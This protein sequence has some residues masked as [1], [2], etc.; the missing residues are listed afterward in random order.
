MLP[1]LLT[2]LLLYCQKKIRRRTGR[3]RKF[4]NEGS[5]IKL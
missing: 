1:L 3:I 4:D 2:E 5:M